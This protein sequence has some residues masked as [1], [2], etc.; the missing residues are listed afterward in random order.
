MVADFAIAFTYRSEVLA[1]IKAISR[2]DSKLVNFDQRQN[3]ILCNKYTRKALILMFILVCVAYPTVGVLLSALSGTSF[4]VVG[5]IAILYLQ[6]VTGSFT[7]TL[8]VTAMILETRFKIVNGIFLKKVC[9][10]NP[11][12]C[13]KVKCLTN[14]HKN[15]IRI[16]GT[17]NEVFAVH[18]LLVIT[19]SCFTLVVRVYSLVHAVIWDSVEELNNSMVSSLTSLTKTVFDLIMIARCSS[20]LCAEANRT[21]VI[22]MRTNLSALQEDERDLVILSSMQLEQ[23]KLEVTACNFFNIDKSLLFT[24]CSVVFSYVFIVVQFDM[25]NI[26][27]NSN[28]TS[29]TNLSKTPEEHF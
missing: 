4:D 29:I 16:S 2:V 24:I 1:Q 26:Q 6:V 9:P 17:V 27:R 7:V 18:L 12:F 25:G 19:M 8:F 28:S 3:I 14:I 13:K 10:Y 23:A 11:N 5:H 20:K 21:K 22:I 15:L